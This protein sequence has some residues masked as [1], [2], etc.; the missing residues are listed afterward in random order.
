MLPYFPNRDRLDQ[1]M[2]KSCQ[3]AKHHGRVEV[4]SQGAS[5]PLYFPTMAHSVAALNAGG[6]AARGSAAS[7]YR[8]KA[9]SYQLSCGRSF[10]PLSG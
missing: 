4:N 8:R 10:L 9:L 1:C 7:A 2:Q 5:G 3:K 6:A